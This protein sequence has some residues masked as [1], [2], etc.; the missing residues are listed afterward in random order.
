[1]SLSHAPI[2]IQMADLTCQQLSFGMVCQTAVRNWSASTSLLW[3][4]R[5]DADL[6]QAPS[7]RSGPRQPLHDNV[8]PVRWG[9]QDG[10]PSPEH[11]HTLSNP[12]PTMPHMSSDQGDLPR[13]GDPHPV[14]FNVGKTNEGT[15]SWFSG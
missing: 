9:S 1:M 10:W 12:L 6:P 14:P 8:E 5:R 15:S 2:P 13:T 11:L 4:A 3:G 7:P